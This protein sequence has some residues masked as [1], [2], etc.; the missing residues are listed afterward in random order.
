[1]KNAKCKMQNVGATSLLLYV[2]AFCIRPSGVAQLLALKKRRASSATPENGTE[3]RG[4]V[5]R[6]IGDKPQLCALS[7]LVVKKLRR[8]YGI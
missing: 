1:M 7:V 8:L 3:G 2:G 4:L 6:H 5:P